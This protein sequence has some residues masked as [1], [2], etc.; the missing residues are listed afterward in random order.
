M[1]VPE[2][3]LKLNIPGKISSKPVEEKNRKENPSHLQFLRRNTLTI[4]RTNM[5]ITI[6]VTI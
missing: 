4:S 5:Y 2:H 3:L 6:I 1:K